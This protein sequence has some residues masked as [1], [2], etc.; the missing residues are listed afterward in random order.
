MYSSFL[1]LSAINILSNLMVPLA[2]IIDVAFLGHLSDIRH[3]AGVSLATVIFNY[4]YW[5]FGFLRMGT[6]GTVAQAVG[7]QDDSDLWRIGIRNSVIAV[8]L[9]IAILFLQ[10][11][12]RELGFFLLSAEPSVEEAGRAFFNARIWGAPAVLVNFVLLGWFLGRSHAS[13]VLVLSI[14][15][16]GANVVL[17]YWMIV[18]LG[19]DS[20]G[21]GLATAL[22]Q[23]AMLLVGIGFIIRERPNR[24]LANIQWTTEMFAWNKLRQVFALNVDILIRTLALVSAFSVFTNLSAAL[25]TT[26]LAVNTLMLQVVTLAAYFIDGLAFATESFAGMIYG[27]GDRLQL[28]PLLKLASGLSIATG[29]MFAGVVVVRPTFLFGLLTIHTEVITAAHDVVGWLIPVL[30]FG[31]IAFIL[32]GYF[33]GLTQ[34]RILR[35]ASILA[36]LCGFVPMAIVAWWQ[37]DQQLLWLAMTLFMISRG[38]AL[39]VKVPDTVRSPT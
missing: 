33:I 29:L 11:P 34:G 16:N 32:D 8:C 20:T 26:M 1:R 36:A 7:R 21:A 4:I 24:H 22:S 25:G 14:I 13:T 5:S 39:G 23:Y 6:T 19:W 27:K 35:N 3:L 30:G 10:H 17:D 37:R 15:G 18:R 28:I 38:I 9:G 2:G 12:L 31:A